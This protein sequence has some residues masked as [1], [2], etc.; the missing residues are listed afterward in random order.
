MSVSEGD[1]QYRFAGLQPG[2]YELKAELQGFATVQVDQLTIT[3]GRQLQQDVTMRLQNLQE[4]VTVTGEAPVEMWH[5]STNSPQ[6]GPSWSP[7]GNS[8][9][10]YGVKDNKPALMRMQVG[11][12][13]VPVVLAFMQR[14][15]PVRWSPRGDWIL[16]RDG[17]SMKA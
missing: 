11:S 17:D 16:Y 3:I 13:A 15:F 6:R 10:Y 9:A 4:T 8:L 5:D 14:A 7:D 12:N 2:T 1:G